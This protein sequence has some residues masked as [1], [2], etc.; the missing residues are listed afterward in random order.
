MTASSALAI[1]QFSEWNLRL[2][3]LWIWALVGLAAGWLVRIAFRGSGSGWV[4]D[5]LLGV[6]GA[7]AAGWLFTRYNILDGEFLYSLVAAATGSFILV[8]LVHI[9]T[10][11]RNR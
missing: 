5:I 10:G 6:A 2:H 8:G 3:S 1:V 9:V 11:E 7:V 4:T